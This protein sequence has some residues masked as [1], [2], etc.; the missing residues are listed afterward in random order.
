[1]GAVVQVCLAYGRLHK[2]FD[3]LVLESAYPLTVNI[4]LAQVK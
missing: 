2:R 1:M 3:G 4:K